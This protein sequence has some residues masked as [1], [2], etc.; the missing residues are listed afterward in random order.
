MWSRFVRDAYPSE[1]VWV[2]DNEND[3]AQADHVIVWWVC[4]L[5]VVEIH[6]QSSARL[7]DNESIIVCVFTD[8]DDLSGEE[9]MGIRCCGVH[10]GRAEGDDEVRCALRVMG[11]REREP[12]VKMVSSGAANTAE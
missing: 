12:V 1:L 9:K 5:L 7:W 6:S 4:S 10:K 11:E 3:I 2:D 8:D